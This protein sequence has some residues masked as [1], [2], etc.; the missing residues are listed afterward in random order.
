M[1]INRDFSKPVWAL[2]PL[3]S[4]EASRLIQVKK[5]VVII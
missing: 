3:I 2:S 5:D 4:S 1:V